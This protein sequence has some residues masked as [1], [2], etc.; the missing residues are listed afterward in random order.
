MGRGKRIFS[1]ALGL[2]LLL[3]LL[4][5]GASAGY[6][7]FTD[8]NKITHPDAVKL[9]VE[10]HVVAGKEDGS[11]FDPQGTLTRA[12][13]AKLI[14]VVLSG[15]AEPTLGSTDQLS[16]S[17]TKNTWG[18]AYIEYVT[19]RGIVAGDG[20]GHFRPNDMVTGTQLAKM[21]L[22]ALGYDAKTEGMVGSQWS[23]KIDALAQKNGLYNGLN[24][25]DFS[26]PL[27]R[28]DAALMVYHALFT[29]TVQY[30]ASG[31]ARTG[32]TGLNQYFQMDLLTGVVVANDVFTLSAGTTTAAPAGKSKL[33]IRTRNLGTEGT[34]LWYEGNTVTLPLDCEN[35]WVG[36]EIQVLV[37]NLGGN[38]PSVYGTAVLTGRNKQ[39]ST[40]DALTADGVT[41]LLSQAGLR[42]ADAVVVAENGRV[43]GVQTVKKAQSSFQ[44]KLGGV[45]R[46]A[47]D[48][49]GDGIVDC[50][51]R[52]QPVLSRVS[53]VE[54]DQSVS[55]EGFGTI[56]AENLSLAGSV[57]PN[58]MV[59]LYR[60]G[61]SMIYLEKAKTV[62]GTISAYQSSSS[63]MTI[64]GKSYAQSALLC[65]AEG[66]A[67]AVPSENLVGTRHLF[68][69]DA[70][71]NLI[72]YDPLEEF[73]VV[74]EPV[75]EG[76]GLV[77]SANVTAAGTGVKGTVSLL[78]ESGNQKTYTVTA[79]EG[80]AASA[81]NLQGSIVAYQADAGGNA[82]LV[83]TQ[84]DGTHN[85]QEQAVSSNSSYAQDG[86]SIVPGNNTIYFFQ[87]G[88]N[89]WVVTGVQN[90]PAAAGSTIR[91][92]AYAEENG[93][94]IALAA[95]VESGSAQANDYVYVLKGPITVNPTGV[96]EYVYYVTYGKD[97]T[98][99]I[100]T[101]FSRKSYSQTGLYHQSG[102]AKNAVLTKDTLIQSGTIQQI[103]AGGT[104]LKL[105][106]QTYSVTSNAVVLDVMDV[107][108]PSIIQWEDLRVGDQIS[109]G[110]NQSG[111]I[112]EIYLVNG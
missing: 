60:Y 55:V 73:P 15:G 27:S 32:K 22:V 18:A 100:D 66:M 38:S 7:E 10:L 93:K 63:S 68:Y 84:A 86:C 39:V 81:Q 107:E 56:A 21:L 83:S 111:A 30:S 43:T 61:P 106:G 99:M 110:L 51:L 9:L 92:V 6:D 74:P 4:A 36:Q 24:A 20:H 96:T 108:M 35:S 79:W 69:L 80:L 41:Q 103:S 65:I 29:N 42:F 37:K 11:F 97:K 57:A 17:D 3:G 77:L 62:T 59:L 13:A 2:A 26:K 52:T 14:C 49:N 72:A 104:A 5:I 85:L 50:V 88:K 87:N 95:R 109:V 25:K 102:T 34:I 12:E 70:Q 67:A 71:N 89:T 44:E 33:F 47:I 19:A 40:A 98:G 28:D 91:E 54:R 1:L 58:D 23:S 53:S 78:T 45:Q 16:Y 94:Y 90:L 105:N 8:K 64:G 101:I 112:Q 46:R 82:I 75:A 76:Y 31:V 48:N